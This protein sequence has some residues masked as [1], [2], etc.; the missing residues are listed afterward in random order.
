VG[1]EQLLKETLTRHKW[2]N[3]L[4]GTA[5]LTG[6]S[7]FRRFPESR[8]RHEIEPPPFFII[9]A[10]RSGNTLL[11]A[12]LVGHSA[13]SI[14]PESY[15]LGTV[16]RKWGR[17]NFLDWQEL[18]KS[19]V[20]EF[21]SHPEFHT[22]QIE[23]WPVY[24]DL[25]DVDSKE[26]SLAR[27]LDAIYRFYSRQKYPGF[28]LWGDKT[29]LNTER[30]QCIDRVFPRARYIHMLR[31]GRDAASSAV[32]AGLFGG[33]TE[34]A[35]RQWLKRVRNARE[36]GSRVGSAR[37]MEL[38]YEDLVSKP[39]EAVEGV[40]GFLGIEF[41]EQMME[42]SRSFEQMGDTT[43]LEHHAKVGQ[44]VTTGSIGKWRERL[45]DEQVRTV[46]KMLRKHLPEY[47]YDGS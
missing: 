38:R 45:G 32:E 19:V 11:R 34:A 30:I 14:P 3:A 15:V 26:R 28:L 43:S 37:Y 24:R 35:C 23:L 20:G 18:V 22:W 39:Y 8:G 9:G 31:D 4:Y 12:L 33:S 17:L 25:L 21:E 41:E 46:E 13:I 1:I 6:A 5:Y 16:V 47:G 40:C 42:H 44:P 7:L 36:M 10:A 2:L 29:P 27:I